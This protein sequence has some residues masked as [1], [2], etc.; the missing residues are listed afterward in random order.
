YFNISVDYLIASTDDEY[1]AKSTQSKNFL[2]RLEELRL[3]RKIKTRYELSQELLI[4]RNNISQWYKLNC[5]PLID[6][7]IIIADYFN[8]SVDYLLGRTDDRTPYK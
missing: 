7:L 1:F 5:L 2:E 6:D 3:E 8:V 4:H